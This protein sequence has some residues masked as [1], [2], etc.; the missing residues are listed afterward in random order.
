[1]KFNQLYEESKD[2]LEFNVLIKCIF[3]F[4]TLFAPLCILT[5]LPINTLYIVVDIMGLLGRY[6]SLIIAIYLTYCIVKM[7]ILQLKISKNKYLVYTSII[8]ILT[9]SLYIICFIKNVLSL[10]L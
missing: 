4:A 7:F 6:G 9:L 2:N 10:L 3:I 8:F 1:M 5:L